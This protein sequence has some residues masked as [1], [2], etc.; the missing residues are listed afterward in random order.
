MVVSWNIVTTP[1]SVLVNVM[2]DKAISNLSPTGH[3]IVHTD[4]GCHY[5]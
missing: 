5:R 4:R 1:N 2:L 3:P